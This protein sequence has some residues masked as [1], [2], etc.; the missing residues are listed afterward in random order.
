MGEL[1]T[2]GDD[3]AERCEDC[4]RRRSSVEPRGADGEPRCMA[5]QARR[6]G[7]DWEVTG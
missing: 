7:L 2:R 3:D 4:G 5:C 6:E 1:W